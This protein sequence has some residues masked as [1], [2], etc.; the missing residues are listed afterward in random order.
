M[1]VPWEDQDLLR[2]LADSI[3]CM[4]PRASKEKKRKVRV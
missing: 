2:E 3:L 1:D 4:N